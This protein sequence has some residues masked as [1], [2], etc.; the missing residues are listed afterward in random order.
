MAEKATGAKLAKLVALAESRGVKIDSVIREVLAYF[1]G[2]NCLVYFHASGFGHQSPDLMRKLS[3]DLGL[4]YADVSMAAALLER[5]GLLE[6]TKGMSSVSGRE[7]WYG[8][9]EYV[10]H[11]LEKVK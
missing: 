4:D 2:G 5:R 9:A 6:E 7:Y 8:L 10:K 1:G 3:G 11:E